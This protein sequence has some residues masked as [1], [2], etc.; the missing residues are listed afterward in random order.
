MLEQQRFLTISEAAGFLHVSEI[1]LRRWT[2]SGKLR[3]FRVGG[4]NERRF[5]VEDLI[6]F[7]PSEDTQPEQRVEH[8]KE[9]SGG[10]RGDNNG[11]RIEPLKAPSPS[12]RR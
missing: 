12:A 4:R 6:A 10:R 2:N 3:C 5:L 1:S 8:E 11:C 9:E 7:M